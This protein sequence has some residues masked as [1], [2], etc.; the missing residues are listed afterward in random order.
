[1]KK[2]LLTLAVIIGIVLAIA[3]TAIAPA[4]A[5]TY[6]FTWNGKGNYSAKGSFSF[7]EK[8]APT[9]FSE[10]GT[11]KTNF[12]ESLNISFLDAANNV[13]SAY[14]NVVNRI[15]TT[16]YFK[17]NFNAKTQEVF[18]LIDFGGEVAGDTYLK[19]IVN[20][21]LSLF[22]VSQ[23]GTDFSRD[24]NSGSLFVKAVPE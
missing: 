1:M 2:L 11:G 18:G 21:N 10:S 4:Q 13:I 16:N 23:S 8:I 24:K 19:G 14:D 20:S 7:D 6:D 22:Q 15:S 17:F 3:F 9:S 5:I 12:L